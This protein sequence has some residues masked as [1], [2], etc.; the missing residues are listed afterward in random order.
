MKHRAIGCLLAVSIILTAAVARTAY[1]PGPLSQQMS[2]RDFVRVNTPAIHILV[3]GE[4][5]FRK[6]RR[7]QFSRL[8]NTN[9][10]IFR[11]DTSGTLYFELKQFWMSAQSLSGPW[12]ADPSPP[13]AIADVDGRGD[14]D[15]VGELD[16]ELA[17]IHG[18]P[19]PH[20]IVSVQR[21]SDAWRE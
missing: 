14:K 2:A 19:A 4:P 1:K 5:V 3:H 21:R 11:D 10:R 9:A 16:R 12:W 20:V 6:I 17:E 18:I 13:I 8:S 7:T 15:T